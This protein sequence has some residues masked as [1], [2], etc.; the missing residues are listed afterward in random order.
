MS[1]PRNTSSSRSIP[2]CSETFIAIDDWLDV[3]RSGRSSPSEKYAHALDAMNRG[4]LND[5]GVLITPSSRS[6]NA[7]II[8]TTNTTIGAVPLLSPK[9]GRPDLGL[10]IHPRF[11]WS[12]AGE[13]LAGMGFRIVPDLLPLPD[14][15]QSD[16]NIPSW[17]LSSIVLARI[18]KLLDSL[19]RRFVLIDEDRNAP[20]GAV[21]WE[22]YIRARFPH[23]RALSIPCIYPDLRNDEE[24]RSAIHWAI[25][26]HRRALLGQMS[27]GIVVHKLLQLCDNLLSKVRGTQPRLPAG[28]FRKSI[29]RSSL[30]T[31]VF[32]EG[33]QAIDWTVDERGL[34]GVSE[35]AG[36]S[37]RMSMDAFFEAWVEAIADHASK[38]V[39]ATLTVG[40]RNETRV[41][42]DWSP[43]SLGSQR[44]L[45]PDVVIK[46]DDVVVVIDAKYKR[47]ANEIERSGWH[48]VTESVREQHRADV[49]Q[50]LAYSTLFEAPRV[51]ACLA[52]PA[53]PDVWEGLNQRNRVFSRARVRSG[54]RQVELALLAVPLSGHVE[55][56]ARIIQDFVKNA[57]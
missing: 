42:L 55:E 24:I 13:M 31:K 52:Y 46:R 9:T 15:P 41:P 34:A 26:I 32:K 5:F 49:L 2:D 23:G 40:R 56:P 14:L 53:A 25:L 11:Q 7:G 54:S 4:L 44:S 21:K 51:V 38:R 33:L 16:R 6:G 17:V 36:L 57:A 30:V 48:N 47:H 22:Q 12:S 45:L 18:R 39:G 10:I 27:A 8:V 1:A 29:Q 3:P 43:P 50:A 20:V 37:W 28:N 35:L 19:Q